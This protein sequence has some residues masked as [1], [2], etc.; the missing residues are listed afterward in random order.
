[1]HISTLSPSGT[2]MLGVSTLAIISERGQFKL[3]WMKL[4]NNILFL[5][6]DFMRMV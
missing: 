5:D 4:S 2:V 1:M 6:K 3:Y